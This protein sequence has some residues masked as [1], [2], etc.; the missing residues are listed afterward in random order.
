MKGIKH[1]DVGN[2]LTKSEYHGE[3]AHELVNGDTLP[4]NP[5]QGDVFFKTDD[6]HLYIAVTE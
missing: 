4:E 1:V 2:D 5:T 3:E 6:K